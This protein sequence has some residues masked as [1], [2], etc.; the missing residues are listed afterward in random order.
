MNTPT[1]AQLCAFLGGTDEIDGIGFGDRHPTISGAYWWRKHL[2]VFDA[3]ALAQPALAAPVL[4]V[5]DEQWRTS[6]YGKE[7][8]K[9]ADDYI[10]LSRKYSD[11]LAAQQPTPAA[12]PEQGAH[13][14][15]RHALGVQETA[16]YRFDFYAQEIE[17]LKL[18]QVMQTVE[19]SP[20]PC[21][22]CHGAGWH[23]MPCAV[24]AGVEPPKP[25]KMTCTQCRAPSVE[26]AAPVAPT[27]ERVAFEAWAVDSYLLCARHPHG[28]YMS[29]MTRTAWYAW[30]ERAALSAQPQVLSDAQI[31]EV[32]GDYDLGMGTRRELMTRILALQE[33][34][35]K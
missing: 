19:A 4:G 35:A 11:L 15:I 12:N 25:Q 21:F 32:W 9:F 14:W 24:P 31:A 22:M 2:H 30:S 17:A 26:I 23:W 27:D 7:A 6:K 5:S 3:L 28:A 20:K 16:P 18:A 8:A 13:D 33:G 34:G 29:D 1:P 10:E